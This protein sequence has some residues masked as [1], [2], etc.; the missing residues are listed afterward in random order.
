[1]NRA[2]SGR[3]RWR[4]FCHGGLLA[5]AVLAGLLCAVTARPVEASPSV[6]WAGTFG[7]SNVIR[8]VFDEA[9]SS[10]AANSTNYTLDQGRGIIGAAQS[11]GGESVLLLVT[12][13]LETGSDC[14]L[15]V[16]NIRDLA[17]PSNTLSN[18]QVSCHSQYY[19][20]V[21]WDYYKYPRSTPNPGFLP[22]FDSLTPVRSGLTNAFA[23]GMETR[24][25]FFAVRFR[26]Y[27]N[28]TSP[29][30]YTFYS[31]SDNGSMLWIGSAP[32]V[33]NN[34][35][36][37][38]QEASGTTNLAPGLYPITVGFCQ[39]ANQYG[40]TVSWEGPGIAK[41][42][43]PPEV[44]YNTQT[45]FNVPL[46]A[47]PGSL[48]VSALDSTQVRLG[49]VTADTNAQGF[50]IERS[51]DLAAW[52]AIAVMPST[53]SDYDDSGLAAGTLYYYRVSAL[54]DAGCVP[55]AISVAATPSL[56]PDAP[57]AIL[58]QPSSQRVNEGNLVFFKVAATGAAPLTY[59]WSKGG[60]NIANATNDTYVIA[61]VAPSD[62]G[63]YAVTVGDVVTN[64]ASDLA[65]LRVNRPTQGA[66]LFWDADVSTA[67][68]QDGS[69]T[70]INGGNGWYG[71]SGDTG[72]FDNNVAAFGTNLR[73]NC[74]VAL[75]NSVAPAGI[76]FNTA[77]N[78][79]YTIAGSGNINLTNNL[80][81]T[82]NAN[83]VIGTVLS[84]SGGFVKL[85]NGT[86]TLTKANTF[87]GAT[88]ILEG[89]LKLGDPAA[90][91]GTASG[92][93]MS[94]GGTLDVNGQDLSRVGEA[95][96]VSGAGVGGNG[97]LIN[98]SSTEGWLKSVSLAG[99]TTINAAHPLSIGSTSGQDGTLNLN[100]F[101]LTK[102]GPGDWV[103]NG[104]KMTGP[105]NINLNQGTLRLAAYYDD[106]YDPQEA[107]SLSG[108]GTLTVNQ[109]ATLEMDPW[110]LS[111]TLTMPITLNGGTF[112]CD[113]PTAALSISS[114]ITLAATSTFNLNDVANHAVTF[115]GVI[116]G[117]FG[118]I[119]KGSNLMRLSATNT[120]T[121]PTIVNGG[122]LLVNGWLSTNTVTVNSGATLGGTG[123]IA[124]PVIVQSGGILAPGD[125][126]LGALA[127]T[128][129][130]NLAGKVL[131]E[132]SKS[133]TTV[134]ND[135]I[136]GTSTLAYGGAL[137][138]TIIGAVPFAAGDKL[139][140]FK[141]TNYS[142]AFFTMS[143]PTLGA[144]LAWDTSKLA[145]DGSLS[146]VIVTPPQITAFTRVDN[147]TFKFNLTTNS[148]ATSYTLL[149]STNLVTWEPL[150]SA[151]T[152]LNGSY[153]ITDPEAKSSP[154]RFYRLQF[155]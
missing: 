104:V 87:D 139:T 48:S 13:P 27:L 108:N 23:L 103:I 140:L 138:V 56:A 1:M 122:K 149:V 102:T 3:C 64:V 135:R 77:G 76:L 145:V 70:W 91:G 69:G 93:T 49:W 34:G 80:T 133:G 98:S 95:I 131:L 89:T 106:G 35:A 51:L 30:A 88:T 66:T 31:M 21:T 40:L 38:M 136:V 114:P 100:G 62:E 14:Q 119:K 57:A 79:T 97:A 7:C 84:G 153:Y 132:V 144:Q 151:L 128:S 54:N 67:G 111:F 65:L 155:P 12:P 130:L 33:D 86:L 110:N 142:G 101:T 124:G 113:W 137:T 45:P 10:D 99:D 16:R 37:Q 47:A 55:S 22:N 72:W 81:I 6:V 9:V 24:S 129:T 92:T 143:L 152:F 82:A 4:A 28:V 19:P 134:T 116:S 39:Y 85:G 146:V 127:I 53:V 25:A 73:T 141:A 78:G 94:P 63:S 121:G 120:Y 17:T 112:L 15:N 41:Q 83:A 43:I 59:Q 90:L 115:K 105:G 126:G 46:P 5:K 26:G 32:V 74:T 60:T 68:D 75:A 147:S 117:A 109:G 61:A 52:T 18:Q 125:N 148:V 2:T 20:G 150:Q 36:G 107:T 123:V 44:L 58:L 42:A 96:V 50:L 118:F 71:A 11:A 8:V 154:R 29:G